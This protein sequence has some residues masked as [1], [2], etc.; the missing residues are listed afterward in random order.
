MYSSR[1]CDF[2]FSSDLL[3]SL[4]HMLDYNLF[5]YIF[6]VAF[7]IKTWLTVNCLSCCLYSVK[8]VDSKSDVRTQVIADAVF[9][10]NLA[11]LGNFKRGLVWS[12]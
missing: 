3:C 4:I 12:G 1:L 9:L 7:G 6:S 2:E 11:G 8:V 10:G 5:C